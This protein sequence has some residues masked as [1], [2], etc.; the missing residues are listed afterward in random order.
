LNNK[1]PANKKQTKPT[2]SVKNTPD[3][4]QL[5]SKEV[6]RTEK[7]TAKKK[8][9]AK[10]GFIDTIIAKVF[11][12]DQ[13]SSEKEG[14]NTQKNGE[15][16]KKENKNIKNLSLRKQVQYLLALSDKEYSDDKL[17]SS[18]RKY[19]TDTEEHYNTILK[20]FKT[21]IAPSFREVKP[22]MFNLSGMLGKTYYT[23]SY[24]SYMDALWTRDILDYH[25]K[26][27]LSIF[28]YPEDDNR[29]KSMLK[30]R[31]TQL[32]AEIN[33]ALAKG[34]TLDTEIQVQYQ[35]VEMIRQK[36]ATHEERYFET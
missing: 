28:I 16:P 2:V 31:S 20:D 11:M 35:D 21:H 22:T 4:D 15:S 17:T 27:D 26:R 5:A 3:N 29:I 6:D 34:I 13:K 30:Q 32:K 14:G 9:S 23:N 18:L 36:L 33:D 8:T 12:L 24:P 25:G 7:D 10:K 19:I 1:K